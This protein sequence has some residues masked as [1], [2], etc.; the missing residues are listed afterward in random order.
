MVGAHGWVKRVEEVSSFP[1]RCTLLQDAHL[2]VSLYFL[3]VLFSVLLLLYKFL[4]FSINF[5]L[6]STEISK[7]RISSHNSQKSSLNST[8]I[9]MDRDSMLSLGCQYHAFSTVTSVD[10]PKLS[11]THS[12]QFFKFISDHSVQ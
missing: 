2:S 4:L 8:T 11:R 10:I 6:I 7:C 5:L 9:S 12:W 1:P 3:V